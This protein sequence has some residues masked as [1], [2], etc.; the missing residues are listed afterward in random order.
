MGAVLYGY[1]DQTIDEP[2]KTIVTKTLDGKDQIVPNPAYNVWLIQDQQIVAYL[3]RNLSKE[4]L[5]H[6]ASLETSHVIWSAIANMFVAQSRSYINNYRIALYN[7]QK[8]SHSATTFLGHMRS[9]FDELAAAGKRISDEELISFIIV[10]MDMDY[11]PMISALDVRTESLFVD[12]LFGMVANFDQRVE[13]FQGTQART[14]K[15]SANAATRGRGGFSKG[16]HRGGGG[17]DSGQRNDGG[18]SSRKVFPSE[19]VRISV[20]AGVGGI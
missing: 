19:P 7:T 5:V 4:V 3:L 18:D 12:D 10:G 6:V 14:F 11:R 2:P 16:Y 15:S 20:A 17:G 9:L 8:G 1:L 13:M